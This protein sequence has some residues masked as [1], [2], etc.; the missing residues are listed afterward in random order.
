MSKIIGIDASRNRS[1]GAVAHLVG[2]LSGSDPAAFGIE[3][4]HLWAYRSLM[5]KIP[6][7]LWLTKHTPPVLEKSIIHQLL[8]QYI[9]LPREVKEKNCDVLFNTD[10]GSICPYTPCIT[11]SQDLLSF[12]P[13]EMKRYG[14]SIGRLR[15]LLLKWI[16]SRSLT[17]ADIA[18]FL[19]N[20][21]R[22]TIQK[23]IGPLRS[24]IIPHGVGSEFRRNTLESKWVTNEQKAIRCIYVSNA[25]RYK[26]Q[27]HVIKAVEKIRNMGLDVS[28]LLVGGGTGYAQKKLKQQLNKTD[29]DGNYI[30]QLEFVQH[31]RIPELLMQS[32]LFIFAS[33][34]ESLPITLLEAMAAG[35]PIACSDRGPMPEV[36]KDGGIYFDPENPDTIVVAILSII[37]SLDLR[38]NIAKRAKDM[39]ETYDWAR[40]S[41]K[42]WALLSQSAGGA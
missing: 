22:D 33:S 18:I 21:A 28:L 37:V 27:W 8:W 31:E 19:T 9:I 2:L 38:K 5:D 36:L 15:L 6:D 1:G 20:Y 42:T 26:H 25:A 30:E 11:M 24:T 10:A 35:L 29:P 4:V 41:A 14:L 40:S 7:F 34:C 17:R 39:S 23:S 32:D 13:I 12:E 3:H 16:Q